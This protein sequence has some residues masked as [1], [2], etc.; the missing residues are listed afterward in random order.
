MMLD[1]SPVS[2][3]HQPKT[4]SCPTGP[5]LSTEEDELTAHAL[6]SMWHVELGSAMGMQ[7]L[8]ATERELFD[9]T[10]TQ[11]MDFSQG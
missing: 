11:A 1:L 3:P 5:V 2:R 7:S 9:L 4:R 6:Q 8:L 10:H